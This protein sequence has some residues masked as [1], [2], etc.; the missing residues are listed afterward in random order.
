[1]VFFAALAMT[2]AFRLWFAHALPFTGDEAYFYYWG[3][4]PDWG[5]YDHPPMVGWWLGALNA[6]SHAS[7]W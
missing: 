4:T 3:V 2:L 7:W 1:M 6:L 5:F